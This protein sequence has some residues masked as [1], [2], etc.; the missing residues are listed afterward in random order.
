[1]V[2][3]RR[4]AHVVLHV[5][6]LDASIAFYRDVL[7]ME[8]VDYR[9]EQGRSFLSFGHQH[10]DIGLFEDRGERTRGTLGLEHVALQVEGDLDDLKAMYRQLADRGAVFDRIRDHGFSKSMYMHDPD[11][12][13]VEVFIDGFPDQAEGMRYMRE[14]GG[15]G[16]P[17]DVGQGAEALA[18]EAPATPG[19]AAR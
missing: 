13:S 14:H 18:K 19:R 7:G 11:G 15:G 8:L 4:V 16:A 1:M 9:K 12:N 17:L 5:A 3:I 6:D 10:P 2:S